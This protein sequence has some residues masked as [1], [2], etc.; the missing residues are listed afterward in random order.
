MEPYGKEMSSAAIESP[1]MDAP[2]KVVMDGI[3]KQLNEADAVLRDIVGNIIG[4]TGRDEIKE[5]SPAGMQ[6]Q[7]MQID[8]IAGRIMGISHRLQELMFGG[9]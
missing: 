5:L 9:R 1:V 2:L 7:V 3:E 4:T 6:E 8:A